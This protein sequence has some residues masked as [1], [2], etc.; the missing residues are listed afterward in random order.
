MPRSS[1]YSRPSNSLDLFALRDEGPDAGR[2]VE[3]GDA[4][5]ARA[6]PLG[7][8][9]LRHELDLELA[10]QELPLELGVLA[11][12]GGD[13][14]ADLA[15]LEQQAQAPVV[16]AAV[17]RN[18]G[19]VPDAVAPERRD[20]VLRDA[21]EAEAA[22]DERRAVAT[23]ATAASADRDDLIDHREAMITEWFA[24]PPRTRRHRRS[25]DAPGHRTQPR[26]RGR[27]GGRRRDDDRV[28]LLDPEERCLEQV[29]ERRPREEA[30]VRARKQRVRHVVETAG[31]EVRH[32]GPVADVGHRGHDDSRRREPG[33]TRARAAD[34]SSRCSSTSPKST[35][36]KAAG[37]FLAHVFELLGQDPVAHAGGQRRIP[38]IRLD[39]DD[40][41][42][43]RASEGRRPWRRGNSPRPE[44]SAPPPAPFRRG[45]TA[46]GR[47]SRRSGGG[48][49]LER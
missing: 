32:D 9:A 27:A 12:V 37:E 44:P 3:A 30:D 35:A 24:P 10:R 15:R 28:D 38:G 14:L 49:R 31:D 26:Q 1:T 11:D 2:R 45:P 5:S 40:R 34:G 21:A 8:R 33:P 46:P 16:D 42:A 6:H 47:P 29:G 39:A 36:S 48:R 22:D 25:G 7:E 20:Q 19:Q 13:H 23:S 43:R 18:D 17:V 4:G 41:H